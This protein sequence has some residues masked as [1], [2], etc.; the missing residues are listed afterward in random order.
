MTALAK[1]LLTI[2]IALRPYYGDG[3]TAVERKARLTMVAI[4]IDQTA[5]PAR[6]PV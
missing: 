2:L 4:A 3:E 1:L 5:Q 6:E